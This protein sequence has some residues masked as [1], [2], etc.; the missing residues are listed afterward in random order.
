[1]R[2]CSICRGNYLANYY[3]NNISYGF[4]MY[5]YIKFYYKK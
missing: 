3:W 4:N 2:T 5:Q 1:M